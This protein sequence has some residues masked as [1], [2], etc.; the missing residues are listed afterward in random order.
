MNSWATIKQAPFLSWI[1]NSYPY[2]VTYS[3]KQNFT[4]LSPKNIIT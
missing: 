1:E 3:E 2:Y 4:P